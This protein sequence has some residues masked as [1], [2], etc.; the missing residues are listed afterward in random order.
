M[1]NTAYQAYNDFSYTG[2]LLW[3]LQT[4]Y[5]LPDINC[6]DN[7]SIDLSI[8]KGLLVGLWVPNMMQCQNVVES[9]CHDG[10]VPGYPVQPLTLMVH[11][12]RLCFVVTG[13]LECFFLS[14]KVGFHMG[15][16]LSFLCLNF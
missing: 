5:S 6:L 1:T 8:E 9:V 3:L 16:H 13:K 2:W 10:F 14:K 12:T 7:K 11:D 15:P 4:T